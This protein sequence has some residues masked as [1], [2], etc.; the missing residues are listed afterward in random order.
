MSVIA[1]FS[2]TEEFWTHGKNKE[3]K[4]FK[5][6]LLSG[7]FCS[8]GKNTNKQSYNYVERRQIVHLNKCFFSPGRGKA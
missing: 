7:D 4:A 5:N 1:G 2:L 8:V 6:S 3:K